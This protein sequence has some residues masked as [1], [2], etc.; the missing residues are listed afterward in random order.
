MPV[1]DNTQEF[2]RKF[3][4]KIV[5]G[6][7]AA[8]Q[9]IVEE[10]RQRIS[11]PYPPASQPGEYPHLRTGQGSDNLDFFVEEESLELAVGFRQDIGPYPPHVIPGGQHMEILRQLF[12]RK[13]LD[14]TILDI[15]PEIVDSF[16]T[17]FRSG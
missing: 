7:K 8:G 9:T 16:R 2:L 1:E 11:T 10:H 17:G 6:L 5:A 15:Q 3:E 4:D 13:G 14:H 12:D